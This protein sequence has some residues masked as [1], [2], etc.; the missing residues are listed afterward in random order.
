M[1][2]F[3]SSLTLRHFVG[4]VTLATFNRRYFVLHHFNVAPFY[5]HHIVGVK[6]SCAVLSRSDVILFNLI[7]VYILLIFLE[8]LL[9]GSLLL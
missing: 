9:T 1:Q 2:K 6:S 4:T 8:V 7:I 5:I 3:D